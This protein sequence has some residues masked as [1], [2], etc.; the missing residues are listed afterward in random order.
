MD[1]KQIMHCFLKVTHFE[2]RSYPTMMG[3]LHDVLV[4]QDCCKLRSW[5]LNGPYCCSLWM[6]LLVGF[7][8]WWSSG[9]YPM[10]SLYSS[11]HSSKLNSVFAHSCH[12]FQTVLIFLFVLVDCQ[13]LDSFSKLL[14]LPLCKQLL[15]WR[16]SHWFYRSVLYSSSL[17]RPFGIVDLPTQHPS[18]PVYVKFGAVPDS[19]SD[20]RYFCYW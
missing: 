4:A 6:E 14:V 2:H 11:I 17:L 10:L 7:A 3:C 18:L 8:V 12:W 19:I 5:W 20:F 9:C 16:L 13:F 1:S 15:C